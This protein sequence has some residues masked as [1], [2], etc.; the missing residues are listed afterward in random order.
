MNAKKKKKVLKTLQNFTILG[1]QTNKFSQAAYDLK[2]IKKL[3]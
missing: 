2:K 3:F 1:I